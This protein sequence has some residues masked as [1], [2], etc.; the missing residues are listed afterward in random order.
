AMG[1]W[2]AAETVP[3]DYALIAAPFA[4]PGHVDEI[5]FLEQIHDFD[6][7]PYFEIGAVTKFAQDGGHLARL[8][9]VLALCLTQPLRFRLAEA[10]LHRRVAV[11]FARALLNHRAGP[12]Q[13]H[14]DGYEFATLDE[15]LRH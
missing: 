13:N 15:Y 2:K 6:L 5:A 3:L 11:R 1:R 9:A 12:R 7:G 4:D 14:G 10:E 8:L